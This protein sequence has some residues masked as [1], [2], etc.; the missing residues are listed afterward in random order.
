[1][2]SDK[3]SVRPP[4]DSFEDCGGRVQ[5]G[6][7]AIGAN[8]RVQALSSRLVFPVGEAAGDDDGDDLLCRPCEGE[9]LIAD[10]E[11]E[12]VVLPGCL[13]YVYQPTRSEYLDHCITHF[14]FRA[15]CKH[16]LEGRGREMAPS[17]L[18]GAKG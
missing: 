4:Q 11:E 12:Q 14:P 15:W 1:M 3:Y 9:E 8:S 16:C 6:D 17:N 10:G 13:P 18:Q 2:K 7:E 5:A